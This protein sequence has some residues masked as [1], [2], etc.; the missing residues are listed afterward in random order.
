MKSPLAG[1]NIGGPDAPGVHGRSLGRR[2]CSGGHLIAL[3]GRAVGSAKSAGMGFS[4]N[5]REEIPPLPRAFLSP[6]LGKR[7][8]R[9][10]VVAVELDGPVP[11]PYGAR[12]RA[13]NLEGPRQATL[14]RPGTSRRRR[15]SLLRPC[16]R[17]PPPAHPTRRHRTSMSGRRKPFRTVDK[18]ERQRC[19]RPPSRVR[20]K[21]A[22]SSRNWGWLRSIGERPCRT[23]SSARTLGRTDT[24]ERP[25]RTDLRPPAPQR[26]RCRLSRLPRC[27]RRYQP[28][29]PT[30]CHCAS[31]EGSEEQSWSCSTR[32]RS[33]DDEEA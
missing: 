9:G 32:V 16:T 23:S 24:R 7:G 29:P 12:F 17:A 5:M 10:L 30:R 25:G 11:S 15:R 2:A 13:L 22:A 6:K 27:K 19:T 4:K 18:R 1:R 21:R 33:P 26:I 14:P 20:R 3:P 28:R 31:D 8:A